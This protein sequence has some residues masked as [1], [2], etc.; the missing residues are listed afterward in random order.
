LLP[1]HFPIRPIWRIWPRTGL[2]TTIVAVSKPGGNSSCS[3]G[4]GMG[5]HG[6]PILMS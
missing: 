2:S 3:T 1:R 5:C 6:K 4:S